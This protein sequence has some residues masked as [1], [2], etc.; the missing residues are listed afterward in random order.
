MTESIDTRAEDV[1]TRMELP[2][3]LVAHYVLRRKPAPWVPPAA[4]GQ[5]GSPVEPPWGPCMTQEE[6]DRL[7]FGHFPPGH[8]LHGARS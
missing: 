1:V 4:S 6:A 2:H 8:P 7:A 5:D 3:G